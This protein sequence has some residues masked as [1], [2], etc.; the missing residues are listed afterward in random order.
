MK[1]EQAEV[2]HSKSPFM[3]RTKHCYIRVLLV[4]MGGRNLS[5][6]FI[7]GISAYGFRIWRCTAC[8][9]IDDSPRVCGLVFTYLKVGS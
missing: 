4:Y 6:L 8:G 1:E 3:D 7:R 9:M 2:L 5:T